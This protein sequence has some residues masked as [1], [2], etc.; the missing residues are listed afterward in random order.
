MDEM[1]HDLALLIDADNIGPSALSFVMARASR[2]GR[3]VIRQAFGDWSVLRSGEWKDALVRHALEPIHQPRCTKTKNSTDIALTIMAMDL[4]YERPDLGAFCIVSSDS[5][6]TGLL[7]RLR[8]SGRQ[9]YCIGRAGAPEALRQ[10]G[11]QFIEIPSRAQ[12][13]FQPECSDPTTLSAL[14]EVF[15]GL[16]RTV[17]AHEMLV[18]LS[19]V[20]NVLYGAG[21]ITH[22]PTCGDRGT[23]S[24]FLEKHGYPVV[25]RGSNSYICLPEHSPVSGSVMEIDYGPVHPVS[26]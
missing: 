12:A 11:D 13:C 4:L 10:A 17:K 18:P 14:R 3:P 23:L 25:S 5:D 8:R 21:A 7:A 9:A 2:L 15:E 1:E 19:A 26:A 16:P 22:C 24:R 6:F 20:G